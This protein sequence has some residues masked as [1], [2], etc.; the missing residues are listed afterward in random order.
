MNPE[1]ELQPEVREY[2]ERTDR[3]IAAAMQQ[4]PVPEGLAERILA[5]LAHQQPAAA[6]S[7]GDHGPAITR[8]R[9]WAIAR[10]RRAPRFKVALGGAAVAAAIGLVAF[11]LRP[12]REPIDAAYVE[13]LA[14]DL[15]AADDRDADLFAT[16]VPRDFPLDAR[17]STGRVYGWRKVAR[18]LLDLPTIAYELT[19]RR[20]ARATLY[21]VSSKS[22]DLTRIGVAPQPAI[23]TGGVTI[24]VWQNGGQ[25]YVL[26]VQGGPAEFQSYF[27]QSSVA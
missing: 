23:S 9:P 4:V 5:N 21:V 1:D 19:S 3:A 18:G 20:N 13:Q 15:Y 22:L 17:L 26:V 27:P 2:I 12:A 8:P 7:A 6:C 11:A 16:D 10:R 25:L 24:G 14:Q